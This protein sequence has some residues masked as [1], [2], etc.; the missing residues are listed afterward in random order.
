[1]FEKTVYNKKLINFNF[2]QILLGLSNEGGRNLGSGH[3]ARMREF[4]S[5]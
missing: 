5:A 3:V 2:R 4:R 1:M